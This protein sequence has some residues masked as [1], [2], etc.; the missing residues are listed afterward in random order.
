MAEARAAGSLPVANVQVL[1]EA[2]NGGAD[3]DRQQVPERYLSKDPS[4]EEV[5][6]GEEIPVI[7]LR[8]L[9]DPRSSEEECAKLASACLNWGFFQ[10]I[11][12]G[13]PEEVTGDLMDDVVEFFK[14]PL[15]DKKECSQQADSLEG[16]GQ[17]FVVSDDQK[18][19][20]ADMLYLQV[21]PTESRDLRFWPTRPASF[22]HS[23]DVHSSEARQLAYRLLEF[24]ARGVGAEPASRRGVF[25]GQT[26]GMRVNYYPPCRQQ[27]DRVLGLTA[28]TDA[29]GLTLLLQK[30][31][32]VQGLQVKKDGR[33]FAV[34]ALEG[35]FIVNVGD[36]LEIMSNGKF[37]SVEHRAVIHP[38]KERISVALF[39][40][41]CQDMVVVGPLPELMKGDK[42]RYRSTNYQDFL[43]QYF[44]EKLDGRKHLERLKLEQ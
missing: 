5:V 6:A 39:H 21:H 31:H 22:G 34:K 13:L 27:A 43:K 37:T 35:A 41:P 42:V 25:E 3:D 11:N 16:Y 15:E 38:T 23:V 17:A 28:H 1:A 7:D 4:S 20:W 14:Q 32:D 44:T 26:Q 19:D 40:Y 12:H 8:K 24:M 30:N 2:C 36:V 10:L 29:C 33:W 9:Q 18:L